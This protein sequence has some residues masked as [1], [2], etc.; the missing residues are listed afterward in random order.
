MSYRRQHTV[1]QRVD[2]LACAV[3]AAPAWRHTR[4]AVFFSLVKRG[5]VVRVATSGSRDFSDTRIVRA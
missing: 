1:L 5:L 4:L 3:S 2:F